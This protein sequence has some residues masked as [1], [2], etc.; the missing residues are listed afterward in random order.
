MSVSDHLLITIYGISRVLEN[1]IRYLI[2][3]SSSE[4]LK[5]P[6]LSFCGASI[7]RN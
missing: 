6:N 3:Y 2:E 4:R 1:S 5:S 7:R